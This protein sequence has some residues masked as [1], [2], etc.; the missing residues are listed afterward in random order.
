SPCKLGETP[1]VQALRGTIG[2]VEP[3]QR[4]GI[5]APTAQKLCAQQG[6]IPFKR[7]PSGAVSESQNLKRESKSLILSLELTQRADFVTRTYT[8]LSRLRACQKYFF[9]KLRKSPA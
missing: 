2:Q 8:A 6:A 7:E 9:D 1:I 4:C 3:M 5:S